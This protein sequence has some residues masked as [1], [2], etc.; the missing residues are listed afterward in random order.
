MR[1]QVELDGETTSVELVERAGR[2]YVVRDGAE[3]PVEL[4]GIRNGAYSLFHGDASIPVVAS[5]GNDDLLLTLGAETWRCAVRD[6]REALAEAA[7]GAKGGRRA[8]GTV[9]ALMPGIVRE[10]LVRVGDAVARGQA[11]LIL[12]A[13]KM[14]NEVRADASGVVES[15]HVAAGDAVAKGDPLLTLR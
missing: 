8:G 5:G 11:L 13:M 3:V 15:V 9:R 14:Q 2:T 10:V 12:E 6:E 1:D 4:C 7:L